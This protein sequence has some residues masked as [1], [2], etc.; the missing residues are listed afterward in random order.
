MR[1]RWHKKKYSCLFRNS[2]YGK[3]IL[4]KW[5]RI[6]SRILTTVPILIVP[7][8]SVSFTRLLVSSS[9]SSQFVV[10]SLLK[11]FTPGAVKEAT[12]RK[13]P[14]TKCKMHAPRFHLYKVLSLIEV[15]S[16]PSISHTGPS[17]KQLAKWAYENELS[18]MEELKCAEQRAVF[19]VQKDLNRGTSAELIWC[20]IMHNILTYTFFCHSLGIC[21]VRCSALFSATVLQ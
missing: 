6:V 21:W 18:L 11:S 9:Y 19:L 13:V 12:K 17:S 5:V 2:A 1:H 16:T 14:C 4:T 15:I 20:R 8:V 7:I 3:Q 10:M